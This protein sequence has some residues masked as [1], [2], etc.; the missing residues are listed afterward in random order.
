MLVRPV[1]DEPASVPRCRLQPR[2]THAQLFGVVALIVD[3]ERIVVVNVNVNVGVMPVLVL[4][5][6]VVL[7]DA[8]LRAAVAGAAHLHRPLAH[9]RALR[10]LVVPTGAIVAAAGAPLTCTASRRGSP[11]VARRA[12]GGVRVEHLVV[13]GVGRKES[14]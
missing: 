12:G 14:G 7:D 5:L 1:H 9:D 8:Q 2:R 3:H 11:S 13:V 10:A 6:V 4:V